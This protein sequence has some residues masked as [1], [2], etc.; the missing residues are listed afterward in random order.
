MSGGKKEKMKD[1]IMRIENEIEKRNI[2]DLQSRKS[3]LSN[4]MSKAS[5]TRSM[6]ELDTSNY[7]SNNTYNGRQNNKSLSHRNDETGCTETLD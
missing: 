5:H 2:L 1:R 6:T 7:N 4:S 3:D